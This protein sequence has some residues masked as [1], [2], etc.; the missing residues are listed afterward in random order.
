MRAAASG[1][2]ALCAY[3]ALAE[4]AGS[5]HPLLDVETAGLVFEM[6]RRFVVRRL[7]TGFGP[8]ADVGTVETFGLF[9]QIW[10]DHA[11]YSAHYKEEIRKV[12][13]QSGCYDGS[14]I[15]DH[16]KLEVFVKSDETRLGKEPHIDGAVMTPGAMV[17]PR[18]IF[19]FLYMMLTS[20][21]RAIYFTS[22]L[23]KGW[24][25][26]PDF[27]DVVWGAGMT[28]VDFGRWVA[29]AMVLK[30]RACAVGDDSYVVT[31]AGNI[32]MIDC[33][34]FEG[35]VSWKLYEMYADS[36]LVAWGLSAEMRKV[37]VEQIKKPYGS[38]RFT[39]GSGKRGKWV[40]SESDTLGKYAG[41]MPSGRGDTG[42]SNS[43]INMAILWYGIS[44]GL[45]TE[46][47]WVD[48]YTRM[49]FNVKVGVIPGGPTLQM[50]ARSEMCNQV[51]MPVVIDGEDRWLLTGKFARGMTK[52]GVLRRCFGNPKQH[53]DW[54]RSA[55]MSAALNFQGYPKL[56]E[57]LLRYAYGADPIK[58]H[59][60]SFHQERYAGVSA[61]PLFDSWLVC[62]YGEGSVGAYY[63]LVEELD[64]W[65][66]VEE[67]NVRMPVPGVWGTRAQWKIFSDVDVERFD[68]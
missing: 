5:R 16:F 19:S 38:I 64:N 66:F 10:L 36:V 35:S 15:R 6:W 11:P 29:R 42:F 26:D 20:V 51:V 13:N 24:W 30:G 33:T 55:M 31:K 46:E 23:M 2:C 59:P 43:N 62:R 4:R 58:K 22:F 60:Y 7:P 37:L 25:T 57:I 21:L 18:G 48:L 1:G 61:S 50:L 3:V 49:G 28:G 9:G 34:A 17:K 53:M 63:S 39:G 67:S 27:N 45:E 41:F 40:F 54:F 44:N 32:L 52:M 56:F 68:W 65:P 8:G 47:Q 12:M 14:T